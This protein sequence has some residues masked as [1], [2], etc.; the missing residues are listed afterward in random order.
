MPMIT[1]GSWVEVFLPGSYRNV[2]DWYKARVTKVNEASAT[3]EVVF[4]DG[5]RKDDVDLTNSGIRMPVEPIMRRFVRG[6]H[7]AMFHTLF[8]EVA[9][10]ADKCNYWFGASLVW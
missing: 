9:A 5:F 10:Q 3:C 7:V 4:F 2:A 6:D 8:A 1:E